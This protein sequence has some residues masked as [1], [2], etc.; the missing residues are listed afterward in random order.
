MSKTHVRHRLLRHYNLRR[1]PGSLKHR[2][3]GDD[4]EERLLEARAQADPL[5]QEEDSPQDD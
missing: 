4:E 3:R 1:V 2:F 5:L